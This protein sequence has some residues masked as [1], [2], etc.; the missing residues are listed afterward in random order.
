[1]APPPPP[2]PPVCGGCPG[3][4]TADCPW[5]LI[6]EP[7]SITPAAPD[8]GEGEELCCTGRED[9]SGSDCRDVGHDD[10]RGEKASVR[11]M[12]MMMMMMI[13]MM[14]RKRKR[15]RRRRRRRRII[16]AQNHQGEGGPSK[17]YGQ[18][19]GRLTN[20]ILSPSSKSSPLLPLLSILPTSGVDR[21]LCSPLPMAT[22]P[23][24]VPPRILR[25]IILPPV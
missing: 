23:P 6:D 19:H 2:I 5:H 11:M 3:E 25:G 14:W 13:L 10:E 20:T 7:A 12:M 8:P 16:L 4:G 9:W 1:M 15:R 17:K 24:S 21:A 18:G 22:T